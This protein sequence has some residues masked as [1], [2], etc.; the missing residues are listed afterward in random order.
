VQCQLDC[1]RELNRNADRLKALKNL[2]SGLSETYQTILDSIGQV[3]DNITIVKTALI[4]LMYCRRHLNIHELCIAVTIDPEDTVF[5]EENAL[6]ECDTLLKLCGPL[7]RIKK[8]NSIIQL[9]HFSV[10]EFLSSKSLPDGTHNKYFV[11]EQD[12]HY[13]IMRACLVY[14]ISFP[15]D[16]AEHNPNN[17][18]ELRLRIIVFPL[19]AYASLQWSA[20]AVQTVSNNVTSSLIHLLLG[21]NSRAFRAWA[22]IWESGNA[23][24]RSEYIM[25]AFALEN[26]TVSN[27]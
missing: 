27:I 3:K 22:Q 16:A 20:H 15:L 7:V 18:I 12:A 13:L 23:D 21:S 17:N 8:Q 14:L 26:L 1:I 2:P 25:G 19:L 24:V 4:W 5:S 9:S 6:D 10:S 11:N